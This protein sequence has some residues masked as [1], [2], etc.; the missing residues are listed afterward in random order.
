MNIPLNRWFVLA[1]S[2]FCLVGTGSVFAANQNGD[3]QK[4]DEPQ[5]TRG[6]IIEM[7]KQS[8]KFNI[9]LKAIEVT[10]LTEEFEKEGPVT[11]LAPTD[12]A[13]KRMSQ[14]ELDDLLADKE[15]LRDLVL[16][17]V[18]DGAVKINDMIARTELKS[19]EG[20]TLFVYKNEAG[21]FVNDA[22]VLMADIEATNGIAHVIDTVLFPWK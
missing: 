11:V 3:D 20:D 9:L 14:Q 18:V 17:H 19:R 21:T 4:K 5:V 15:Y 2:L 22:K 13:F 12:D 7:A 10:G 1:V 8:G 16:L 6:S